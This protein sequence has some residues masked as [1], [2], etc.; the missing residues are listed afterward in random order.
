MTALPE[1]FHFG[2]HR[3]K[4]HKPGLE[5]RAG[6]LLKRRVHPAVQ[7]DLVIQRSE[8][9]GNSLLF[10]ER[11]NVHW[12][13]M[14]EVAIQRRLSAAGIVAFEI[15]H[16]EK[17]VGEALVVSMEINDV[18]SSIQWP[19]VGSRVADDPVR[20]T[21]SSHCDARPSRFRFVVPTSDTKRP[22]N[23]YEP[24]LTILIRKI[25]TTLKCHEFTEWQPFPLTRH[26]LILSSL[27]S[28][29]RLRSFT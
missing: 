29:Q 3:L 27:S 20:C 25:V 7:F 15:E 13:W 21:A 24:R 19:I 6:H 16:L 11:R 4:I 2:A 8:D 28:C 9:V 22:E 26:S 1:A 5:N 23:R 10:G 18:K 14:D 12:N 17:V